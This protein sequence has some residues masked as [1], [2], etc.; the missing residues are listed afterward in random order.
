MTEQVP[1][2]KSRKAPPADALLSAACGIVLR[3]GLAGLT[4]RPLAEALEVSVTVLSNQ[5]GARADIVAAICRAAR[6]HDTALLAEW[7]QTLAALDRLSPAIAAELAE[8]VL[9]DLSVRQREVSLLY[10]EML[11]ACT[12]DAA[13]RP[14]F[15]EWAA[16]RNGFW[17]GFAEQAGMSSL[18][19]DSGWW[20][21]YVIAEL[22]YSMASNGM[23]AYRMLRRLCLRRLFA[24]GLASPPDSGDGALFA[25]LLG[26]MKYDGGAALSP[27]AG[28]VTEWST[29][30]ARA[31]GMWLAAQGINGLTHRAIAAQIGIPHTTLSYRYP[32]QHDL[33]LAGLESI[34]AHILSAVDSESL[35]ELQ[36]LRTE[37]DGKKLDLARANF[38]VAIAAARMPELA[39]YTVNMRSRRGGHLVKVFRKYLPDTPGIDA[40]CA[41]VIS[42]GLTGITN[43][44]PPGEAS[45]KTVASAFGAAARWLQLHHSA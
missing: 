11:H 40:L 17:R 22:A 2:R 1:A 27:P 39:A 9:D 5:Y 13:L 26:Q 25:V 41:Q 34:I 15:A 38:A 7:R 24:G 6:A 42:M 16:A 14:V 20:Q 23:P 35:D 3:D 33:V 32:T 36:R 12:W 31:C 21:G 44:E 18:L 10:L 8:A 43:T 29:Q 30:A 19:L 28:R 4:L 37:G 45:D